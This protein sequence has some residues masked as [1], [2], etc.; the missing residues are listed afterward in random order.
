MNYG[1]KR[2][3]KWVTIVGAH[4]RKNDR[5]NPQGI[6]MIEVQRNPNAIKK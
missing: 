3:C 6:M 2:P 4:R 1:Q 5:Q